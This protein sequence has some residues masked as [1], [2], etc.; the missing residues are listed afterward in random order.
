MGVEMAYQYNGEFQEM[1]DVNFSD[2]EL[3]CHVRDALI[4]VQTVSIVVVCALRV[5]ESLNLYINVRADR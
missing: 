4:S 1:E 3:V 2:S 5:Y